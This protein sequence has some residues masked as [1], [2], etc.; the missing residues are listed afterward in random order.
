MNSDVGITGAPDQCRVPWLF[1]ERRL[2]L[3]ALAIV[4]ATTANYAA[5]WVMWLFGGKPVFHNANCIDF[6]WIWL[7]SRFAASAVPMH[8]YDYAAFVSAKLALVGPP[9]CILE[10]FDYPPTLLFFLYPLS[11]LPYSIAFVAWLAV[12][13]V[14]Y[15]ASVYAIMPHRTALIVALA[16]APVWNNVLLGHNGFLTA[17]L[18]GFALVLAE[19]RPRLAAIPLSLLTYKPQFGVLFPL[20]LWASRRWRA[21]AAAAIGSVL[22]AAAAGLAFGYETWPAFVHSLS[23]RASALSADPESVK[24]LV[25]LPFLVSLGVSSHVVWGVQICTATCAAV[26]VYLIWKGS[27]P[28]ALKAAALAF[29]SLVASPNVFSYD[30][31]IL[32]IGSLFLVKDGLNRGFLRGERTFLLVCSGLVLLPFTLIPLTA[33]FALLGLTV[34]RVLRCPVQKSA[35]SQTGALKE[36]HA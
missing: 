28:Y 6:T 24:Y 31:C 4:L 36:A 25:S 35:L 7:A 15:L 19:S 29:G 8:V 33:C 23:D 14:V 21:L 12:T 26:L 32:T 13:I 11:A 34:S 27:C 20:A 16:P 9:N 3:L 17:G 2:T 10:H 30:L 18:F 1:T 22:F 5:S